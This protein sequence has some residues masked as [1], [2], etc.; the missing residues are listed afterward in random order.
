MKIVSHREHRDHRGRND[1][2]NDFSVFSVFS[3]AIHPNESR[4][5]S[6]K[7]RMGQTKVCPTLQIGEQRKIEWLRK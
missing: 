5:K 3:V 2:V 6:E 4:C 1:G 7:A